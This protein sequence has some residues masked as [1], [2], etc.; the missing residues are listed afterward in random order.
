MPAAKKQPAPAEWFALLEAHAERLR[1]AGITRIE[2]EGC[3]VDLA[4][5]VEGEGKADGE[6]EAGPVDAWSDPATYGLPDGA[7]VPGF[8]RL[9]NRDDDE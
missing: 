1:K 9:R 8:M 6:D 7:P 4:P 5:Y 2:L 3:V